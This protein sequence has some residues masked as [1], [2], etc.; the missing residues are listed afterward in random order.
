MK[1]FETYDDIINESKALLA[2]VEAQF[3]LKFSGTRQG[4]HGEYFQVTHELVQI[5]FATGRPDNEKSP[6]VYGPHRSE[7]ADYDIDDNGNR[8]W[9]VLMTKE[10]FLE[11]VDKHFEKK[12]TTEFFNDGWSWGIR[13]IL[14]ATKP[15][16]T[17]WRL[18][19]RD[20]PD[21]IFILRE[22]KK[23]VVWTDDLEKGMVWIESKK[24]AIGKELFNTEEQATA[25]L[26]VTI[27][28]DLSALKSNLKYVQANI[29]YLTALKGKVLDKLDTSSAS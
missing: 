3:G 11:L 14:K 20:L 9:K 27:N 2:D 8:T 1:N 29:E 7:V 21:K 16:A 17:M 28:R 23:Q 5:S 13:I 25:A 10:Q 18:N 6:L 26:L 15:V 19:K 4:Q 22:T 24:D 12:V